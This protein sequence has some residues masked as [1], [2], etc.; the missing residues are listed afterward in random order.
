MPFSENHLSEKLDKEGPKTK[1]QRRRSSIAIMMFDSNFFD[2]NTTNFVPKTILKSPDR[3]SLNKEIRTRLKRVYFKV[4]FL[5]LFATFFP[6]IVLPCQLASCCRN[7]ELKNSG[8]NFNL[9]NPIVRSYRS[10]ISKITEMLSRRKSADYFCIVNSFLF[11]QRWGIFMLLPLSYE[12]WAF[13]YRLALGVPAI[14]QVE[15]PN[16]LCRKECK[17]FPI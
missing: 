10:S 7:K 5:L 8:G 17:S 2:S 15:S 9:T 11:S 16:I 3:N 1:L 12:L 6:S 4:E 13:P 14:R